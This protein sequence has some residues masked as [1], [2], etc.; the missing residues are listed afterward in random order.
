MITMDVHVIVL[1]KDSTGEVAWYYN[2]VTDSWVK[3]FQLGC[4]CKDKAE[5]VVVM[6]KLDIFGASILEG[7][8]S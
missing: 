3:D 2:H 1:Y 4:A 8:M 6:D 7:T 5:A